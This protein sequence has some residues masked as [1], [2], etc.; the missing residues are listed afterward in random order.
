MDILNIL[1]SITV[2]FF[3]FILIKQLF[4]KNKICVICAS[5]FITWIIFLVMYWKEI[6][7]DK[8]ILAILIGETTLGIFYLIESKVKENFKIFGL[9]FIMTLILI[10]Y[11]LIEGFNYSLN[12]LY[13]L[14]LLWG[15]FFIFYLFKDEGKMG[16]FA[17]KLVECCKRW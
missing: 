14:I 5:I 17:R 15:L 12:V 10:G 11:T 9:P 16:I 8:T 6:F 4:K 2:L 1:L 7:L 13:F 3:I